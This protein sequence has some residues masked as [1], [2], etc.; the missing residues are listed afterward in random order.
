V[1]GEAAP[2]ALA[3]E[4][5]KVAPK[6]RKKGKGRATN[7]DP[8]VTPMVNNLYGMML[9]LEVQ[10]ISVRILT[11]GIYRCGFWKQ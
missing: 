2:A 3:Q 7:G 6:P 5:K 8:T 10:Y 4:R 1:T 11:W 9:L